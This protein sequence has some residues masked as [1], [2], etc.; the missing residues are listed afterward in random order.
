M[1]ETGRMSCSKPNLTQIAKGTVELGGSFAEHRIRGTVYHAV[2][3]GINPNLDVPL[4]THVKDG[5][6]QGGAPDSGLVTLPDGFDYVLSLYPWGGYVLPEGCERDEIKM[7]D[8][9]DQGF[10]QVDELAQGVATRLEKGQTCLI[11]CQAG[12]NRSG[13]LAA[14]TLIKMGHEP[15]DAINLLRRRSPLVLCNEAFEEHLLTLKAGE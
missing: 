3:K 14:R 7:Y 12:L 2:G 15:H 8:A 13:L 6:Y 9:L 5:L 11:H 4:V 10:E 1:P